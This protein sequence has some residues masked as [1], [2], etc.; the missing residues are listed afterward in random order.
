MHA[1]VIIGSYWP[2]Q[3]II[4]IPHAMPLY[5]F[6]ALLICGIIISPMICC[7]NDNLQYHLLAAT[8]ALTTSKFAC[9]CGN[10]IIQTRLL[11]HFWK[12]CGSET[13]NLGNV[14]SIFRQILWANIRSYCEGYHSLQVDSYSRCHERMFVWSERTSRHFGWRQRS[15][16]VVTADVVHGCCPSAG[17]PC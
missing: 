16:D 9:D 12:F 5:Y 3:L 1:Y 14:P 17:R 15:L 7:M 8:S 11:H 10:D 13:E 4:L 6:N 2:R